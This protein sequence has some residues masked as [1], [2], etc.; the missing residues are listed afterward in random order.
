MVTRCPSMIIIRLPHRTGMRDR[1]SE[2]KNRMAPSI[3]LTDA[4]KTGAVPNPWPGFDDAEAPPEVA[5][6][7]FGIISFPS[8][9]PARYG[10]L[11]GDNAH[12]TADPREAGAL[13][14]RPQG[15]EAIRS[16]WDGIATFR[17]NGTEIKGSEQEQR[18]QASAAGN[19]ATKMKKD[20][21]IKNAGPLFSVNNNGGRYWTRTSDLLHVKQAL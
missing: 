15:P 14:D 12:I 11:S 9:V 21:R 18:E 6:V 16:S 2:S 4:R 8:R 17:R 19:P 3:V 20:L 13:Q 1:V 5:A 10:G 7:G